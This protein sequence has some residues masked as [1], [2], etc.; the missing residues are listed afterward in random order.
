VAGTNGKGSIATLL[1]AILL[2]AYW[3]CG[4]YRSPHLVSWC[5]RIQLNGDWIEA[6]T[7]RSDLSR[8]QA[9]AHRHGLSP[10]EL[11]TAAAFDRFAAADLSLV[12]LEVGL[13][14][15]LDATT[16][17]PDRAVVGFGP[18]GMDH[19]DRLGDTLAAIAREKAG[20]MAGA[21]VAISGPQH[22]EVAEVLRGE[23][24]RL[25]CELRWVDPLAAVADGGPRL[26][27]AG[28]MQ[29][30]NAAVA[31]AMAQA[32]DA[33]GW[34]VSPAAITRGLESARWPG[35]LERRQWQGRPLLLDGAHNHPGALALRD[36]LDRLDAA[37]A[38][39]PRRWLLAI[40]KTKEA[41][42][43]LDALLKDGDQVDLVAVP[44]LP[45]WSRSDLLALRPHL[46]SAIREVATP[47]EGLTWL[48]EG[49]GPL[50]VVAGSLHLLGAVIPHLDQPPHR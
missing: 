43:I 44:D 47:L 9:I 37:A 3:R 42:L 38:D 46:E 50:P 24:D 11:L 48:L 14:G 5:E 34:S 7:L 6:D 39:G 27:L 49:S 35:R 32:L 16:V 17:H 26:G 2:A 10:F 21:R 8:W 30:S 45:S 4:N 25:A 31:V 23:A 40:Q 13:G 20:V 1:H 18:I 28:T 29:R 12:V 41:P 15:R 36:E 19:L 33:L 22:P